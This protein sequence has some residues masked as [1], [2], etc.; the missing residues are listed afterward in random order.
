MITTEPSKAKRGAFIPKWPHL[1]GGLRAIA[2]L[3]KGR[4]L[5]S[6]MSSSSLEDCIFTITSRRYPV[7]IE[8]GKPEWRI[9]NMSFN[10]Y[11]HNTEYLG[12]IFYHGGGK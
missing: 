11:T 1:G 8:R 3:P 2:I 7:G 9:M 5:G 6:H 12:G 10:A 4:G